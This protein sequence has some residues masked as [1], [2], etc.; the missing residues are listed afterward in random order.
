MDSTTD[1]LRETATKLFGE[2]CEAKHLRE[3]EKGVFQS[4][5]WEAV[6]AASEVS[7]LVMDCTTTGWWPPMLTPR[8][9]TTVEVR[10]A[11]PV[12]VLSGGSA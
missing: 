5:A 2:F 7:V 11:D 8:T 4:A 6:A 1:M 12:I 10:R 9:R 3:A